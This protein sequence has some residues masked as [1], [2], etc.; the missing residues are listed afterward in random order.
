MKKQLILLGLAMILLCTVGCFQGENIDLPENAIQFEDLPEVRDLSFEKLVSTFYF[1]QDENDEELYTAETEHFKI[2]SH[3]YPSRYMYYMIDAMNEKYDVN[4]ADYPIAT[5]QVM[6]IHFYREKKEFQR[7][8]FDPTFIAFAEE[9]QIH[10]PVLT[11]AED[12]DY[13]SIH[14]MTYLAS[15]HEMEHVSQYWYFQKPLSEFSQSWLLEAMA[16][17]KT[18]KWQNPE[19]NNFTGRDTFFITDLYSMMGTRWCYTYGFYFIDYLL[20]NYD[21]VLTDIMDQPDVELLTGKSKDEI[22]KDWIK[23]MSD[24]YHLEYESESL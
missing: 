15:I 19:K 9:D 13:N 14:Y 21:I 16:S 10:I 8:M 18:Y 17:Y 5:D 11:E 20:S 6:T 24:K 4:I 3:G 2:I 23:F 12:F 7:M 22:F 1:V